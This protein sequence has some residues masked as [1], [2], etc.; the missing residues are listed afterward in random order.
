MSRMMWD[1]MDEPLSRETK[2]SATNGD[3]EKHIFPDQL[4]TSRIINLTRLIH[5]LSAM[6]EYDDHTSSSSRVCAFASVLVYLYG[7]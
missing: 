7:D 4:T 6:S 5:T 3:R 1:A 2:F